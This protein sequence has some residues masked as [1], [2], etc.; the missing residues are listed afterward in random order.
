MSNWHAGLTEEQKEQRGKQQGINWKKNWNNK[1]E[2]EQKELLQTLN[3]G[4]ENYVANMTDEERVRVS[5]IRRINTQNRWDNM[6]DEE[7][8]KQVAMLQEARNNYYESLSDEEKEARLNKLNEGFRNWRENMTD[9]DR[10]RES[11]ERKARWNKMTDAEKQKSLEVL[12]QEWTRWYNNMTDEEKKEY[13]KSVNKH[14]EEMT[15]EEFIEWTNKREEGITKMYEEMDKPQ[16]VVELEFAADLDRYGI[17]YEWQYLS[18]VIHPE[19]NKLF[20]HNP[21]LDRRV[22]PFHRWDFI[23]ITKHGD[24]LVDV[25]GSFH[26]IGNRYITKFGSKIRSLIRFNDSKRFYQTDGKNAYI[27]QA[28]N[29]QIGPE[30]PVFVVDGRTNAIRSKMTYSQFITSIRFMNFSD[31][32]IKEIMKKQ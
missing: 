16:N 29:D 20:P 26:D 11:A 4:R 24:F 15:E 21:V 27:I 10:A 6:S 19:F 31:E 3:E 8:E 17:N 12:H 22:S 13:R 7:R 23:V 32:E 28:F 25:D 2:E 18:K 9:E 1:S 5:E 14:W 30:T